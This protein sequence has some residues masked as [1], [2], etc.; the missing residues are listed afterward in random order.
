MIT[1][2]ELRKELINLRGTVE[3]RAD[4]D[5]AIR[6]RLFAS[7]LPKDRVL[8]YVSR[9]GEVDTINIILRILDDGG[10]VYV[11]RCTPGENTMNFYEIHSLEELEE[12]SFGIFEPVDECPAAPDINGALCLVPGLSFTEQGDRIGYGKGYYDRFLRENREKSLITVGLCYNELIRQ[13]LP[14]D[15]TDEAVQYMITDKIIK[16]VSACG[17]K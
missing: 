14:V 1:K 17:E 12:G 9:G 2:T 13:E 16:E 4:K 5:I 11:P 15:E 6:E 8:A 3:N 7:S 10:A